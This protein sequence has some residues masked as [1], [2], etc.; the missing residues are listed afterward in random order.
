MVTSDHSSDTGSRAPSLD[1]PARWAGRNWR[2]RCA[3]AVTR[4]PLTVVVAPGATTSAGTWVDTVNP[5]TLVSPRDRGHL[6]GAASAEVDPVSAATF[7]VV[8]AGR[9]ELR[10]G[11]ADFAGRVADQRGA[12]PGPG[13]R[14]H[15]VGGGAGCAGVIRA[16]SQRDA[17]SGE[18][19]LIGS[20]GCWR[21][22]ALRLAVPGP[23]GG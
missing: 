10:G 23:S 12:L 15:L 8:R 5:R 14:G 13:Y 21:S 1:G 7:G 4:Q 2:H 19:P 6:L 17:R 3:P 20:L 22:T 11:R 16:T 18:L 9:A